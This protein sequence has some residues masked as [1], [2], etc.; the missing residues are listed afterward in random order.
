MN[1]YVDVKSE[2]IID[3]D[4][5]VS[6]IYSDIRKTVNDMLKAVK[7][8][9]LNVVITYD[10]DSTIDSVITMQVFNSEIIANLIVANCSHYVDDALECISENDEFKATL[11]ITITEY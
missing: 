11:T 10:V 8:D 6:R 1:N 7:A 2:F 4:V 9:A 3:S 5:V